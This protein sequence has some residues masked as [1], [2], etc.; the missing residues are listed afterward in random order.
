MLLN[1]PIITNKNKIQG[2][3]SGEGLLENEEYVKPRITQPQQ[4]SAYFDCAV[5]NTFLSTSQTFLNNKIRYYV[6]SNAYAA[7]QLSSISQALFKHLKK[8]YYPVML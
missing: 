5:I 3:M 6:E 7:V 2:I 4:K 8:K 1:F